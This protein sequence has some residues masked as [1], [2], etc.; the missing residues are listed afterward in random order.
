MTWPRYSLLDHTVFDRALKSHY[1]DAEIEDLWNGYFAV[2]TC[3]ASNSLFLI[4][5]GPVWKAVRATSSIPGLLPPVYCEDGRVLVDGSLLDN[6]PVKSMRALKSGPNV[7]IGLKSDELRCDTV[8]YSALPSRGRML[9]Q[10]LNP[11]A[12]RQLPR[13]PGV[14]TLLLRS[15]MVRRERLSDSLERDDLLINPPL[16]DDASVMDWH[17]HAEL[18]ELAYDHTTKV[19]ADQRARGHPL[20]R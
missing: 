14:A 1:G 10:L 6:V 16:P 18:A 19:I 9:R 15:L 12:R 5:R 4:T 17:R 20:F 2:S 13:A 11:F 3:L 8:D 7:V